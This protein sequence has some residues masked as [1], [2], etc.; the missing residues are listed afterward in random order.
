[1]LDSFQAS[2]AHEGT[3]EAPYTVRVADPGEY[4]LE[5][6]LFKGASGGDPYRTL[7]LWLT[8]A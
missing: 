7:H 6:R 8:V 4:K 5:F 1:M 3:W 2:V